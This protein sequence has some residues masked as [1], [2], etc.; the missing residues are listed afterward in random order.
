MLHF[1]EGHIGN[2]NNRSQ[3]AVIKCAKICAVIQSGLY[4]PVT[5]FQHANPVFAWIYTACRLVYNKR[6]LWCS[7]Q[8]SSRKCLFSSSICTCQ[9]ICMSISP[10]IP[11][12]LNFLSKSS[13]F[14]EFFY[15]PTELWTSPS[16]WEKLIWILWSAKF[17]L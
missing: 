4:T 3:L 13:C 10:P 11:Q 14:L 12:L 9:S 2:K 16:P 1:C 5:I 6:L 8:A 7:S 17:F 15:P